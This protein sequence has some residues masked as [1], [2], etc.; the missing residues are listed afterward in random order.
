M[1]LVNYFKESPISHSWPQDLNTPMQLWSEKA[2]R[3]GFVGA[4][5]QDVQQRRFYKSSLTSPEDGGTLVTM[6]KKV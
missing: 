2:Y 4:G 1:V 6:G 5:F 3:Q